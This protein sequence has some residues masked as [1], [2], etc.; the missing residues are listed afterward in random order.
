[1]FIFVKRKELLT[2]LTNNGIISTIS[3][4]M[5]NLTPEGEKVL[6]V[7]KY[8]YLCISNGTSLSGINAFQALRN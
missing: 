8:L 1:M 6:R 4:H 5:Y 7:L 2:D 3:N